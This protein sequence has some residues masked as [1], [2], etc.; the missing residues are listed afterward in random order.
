[1]KNKSIYIVLALIGF[2]IPFIGL[3]IGAYLT[4]VGARLKERVIL[5]LGIF[6]LSLGI[7]IV[8]IWGYHTFVDRS[9]FYEAGTTASNERL[10]MLI[11]SIEFYK[12]NNGSYPDNLD[13][14][15]FPSGLYTDMDPL[16]ALAK[17]ANKKFRYIKDGDVYYLF[18]AGVD[19]IDYTQDD[20]LPNTEGM[21][22]IGYRTSP[23]HQALGR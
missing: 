15:N 5:A 14:I 12:Q 10:V 13:L 19:G 20:L 7:V 2:F 8:S 16:Q 17:N 23:K 18:S 21:R 1:M 9:G 22:N 11:E 3:L 6:D 4:F